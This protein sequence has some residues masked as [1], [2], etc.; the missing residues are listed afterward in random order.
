MKHPEKA[1]A[2]RPEEAVGQERETIDAAGEEAL[3]EPVIR[4]DFGDAADVC[5][6]GEE[7][8]R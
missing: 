8:R 1:G 7:D 3:A 6:G 2:E 5:D 4:F